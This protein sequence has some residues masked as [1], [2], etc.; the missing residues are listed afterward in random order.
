[1]HLLETTL[2]SLL[3]LPVIKEML[4]EENFGFG[5]PKKLLGPQIF[6]NPSKIL[7][8]KMPPESGRSITQQIQPG[9]RSEEVEDREQQ[10]DEEVIHCFGE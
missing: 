8:Y 7:G 4:V 10:Q 1:M 6:L 3:R 9:S 2:Q 5:V